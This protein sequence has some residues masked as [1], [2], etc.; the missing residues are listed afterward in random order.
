MRLLI[1]GGTVFLGRHLVDAARAQGHAVTLF[2]RGTHAD[3]H[4]D[5]EQLHGDRRGDLSILAGRTWDAVIDTSGYVPWEVEASCRALRESMAHYTFVSSISVYPEFGHPDYDESTPTRVLDDAALARARA[6][7]GDRAVVLELYGEL[8]AA[9]EHAAT[10][11]LPGRV[12]VVRP[13]LIVGPHDPSDRFTWWVRRIADGGEVL[14]PGA[15]DGPVQL[16]D[17][18]DLAEWI[19]RMVGQRVTG[20]FQATGPERPLTMAEVLEACRA[21]TASEARLTWVDEPFLLESSVGPWMEMP[22]WIPASDPEHRAMCRADVSRARRAGL[23]FRPISETVRDTL[24]WD[25]ARGTPPMK[26]G[27]TREREQELLSRW[28]AAAAG[29]TA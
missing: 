23:A 21:A 6:A 12:L 11:A 4:Q 5:V 9:C 19:V 18:R 13:G 10:T 20:V 8:K 7:D 2:N 15:S 14:A 22:L 17:V 1:L 16:I 25:R 26:A 24:A 3:V 29:R 28:H 27:L